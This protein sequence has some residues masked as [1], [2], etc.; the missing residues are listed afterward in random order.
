M[1]L[2]LCVSLQSKNLNPIN[3]CC[4]L[5]FSGGILLLLWVSQSKLFY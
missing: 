3:L 5:G 2:L 4:A 1:L